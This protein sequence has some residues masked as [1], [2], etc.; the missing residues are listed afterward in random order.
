MAITFGRQTLAR[1]AGFATVLLL[2]I[3]HSQL[4]D[5]FRA[6]TGIQLPNVPLLDHFYLTTIMIVAVFAWLRYRGEDLAPFGLAMTKRW[7]VTIGLG[8]VVL[9]A[10]LF[11]STLITPMINPI[12]VKLTGASPTLAEQHFAPLKGNLEYLLILIPCAWIGGAIGEEW[13]YRGFYMTRIAQFFGNGRAAWGIALFGQAAIFASMHGY[14]GPVGMA[15]IFVAG[16]IY[17]AGTLIWGRSLWPSMIAH[18]LLDTLAFTL[19]YLGI[20][21]A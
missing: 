5:A 21:H 17:G 15:G 18:G 1:L 8:F 13:L 11:Y 9:F 19:M 2:D 6:A 16:L 12:L 20:V 4:A 7:W 3:F 10:D 14:Q